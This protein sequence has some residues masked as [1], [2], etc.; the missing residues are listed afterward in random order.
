MADPSDGSE[1]R[2]QAPKVN[3]ANCAS[4]LTVP[5]RLPN[6]RPQRAG[7]NL[8]LDG[9]WKLSGPMPNSRRPLMIGWD[10]AKTNAKPALVIQAVML[11]LAIGFYTNSAVADALRRLAEYKRE[12]GFA[13]VIVGSVAAGALIPEI[14]LILFFQREIG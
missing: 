3:N 1:T 13:F 12:H 7:K 14:F 5:H 6:R 2:I 11:A 10:A 8:N 9:S 4:E